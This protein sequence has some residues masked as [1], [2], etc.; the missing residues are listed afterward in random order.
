MFKSTKSLIFNGLVHFLFIPQAKSLFQETKERHQRF[1]ESIPEID[2]EKKVI[3]HSFVIIPEL[4]KYLREEGQVLTDLQELKQDL[5]MP[6]EISCYI[7]PSNKAK[8]EAF[9]AEIE[10]LEI[11]INSDIEKTGWEVGKC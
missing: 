11:Q 1:K 5:H 7:S 8:I 6:L 4:I 2:T 9:I 10:A 3:T